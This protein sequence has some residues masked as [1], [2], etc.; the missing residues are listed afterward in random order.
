MDLE[1]R[2]AALESKLHEV[3]ALANLALRL[4]AVEKP[5]AAL[6]QRFGASESESL[7]VHTPLANDEK[8]LLVRMADRS[9]QPLTGSGRPEPVAERVAALGA[10][11]SA[12]SN[13]VYATAGYYAVRPS[14]LAEADGARADG[15]AALRLFLGRLLMRGYQI[16]AI[17][18]EPGVDVDHPADVG[19]AES[20]LR[21]T[22]VS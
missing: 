20:F 15:V 17:P 16:D 4:L 7:A 3:E 11:A 8:P 22:R 2:V 10:D 5:V 19:T 6:L 14:I 9:S 21:Q 18:V 12:G 1:A 13:R